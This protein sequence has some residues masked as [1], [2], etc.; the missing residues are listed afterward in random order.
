MSNVTDITKSAGQLAIEQAEAELAA[1]N[2]K[3]A[4]RALK[5]KLQSL[6]SARKIVAN[7]E[8][9]VADLKASITD[10]SFVG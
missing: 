7:L 2:L 6:D 8:R 1:D 3:A 9:E 5:V 10:G 4:T